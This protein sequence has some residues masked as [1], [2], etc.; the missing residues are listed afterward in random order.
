MII[1]FLCCSSSRQI[2][3]T[4]ETNPTISMGKRKSLLIGHWLWVWDTPVFSIIAHIWHFQVL[5]KFRGGKPQ[6]WTSQ[7][8]PDQVSQH[9][10]SGAPGQKPSW[11]VKQEDDSVTSWNKWM[12][13]RNSEHGKKR[14]IPIPILQTRP[15][16]EIKW[17]A[18]IT[19]ALDLETEFW[20]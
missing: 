16:W 18:Q 7:A 9:F 17:G 5:G 11:D 1:L 8:M 4:S 12:Q 20:V 15:R 2:W 10:L 13:E 3:R 14:R 6:G 19:Q